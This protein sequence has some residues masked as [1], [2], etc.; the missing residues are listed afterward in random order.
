M[1]TTHTPWP[2]SHSSSLED[3]L[4]EHIGVLRQLR[5]LREGQTETNDRLNVLNNAL[6]RVLDSRSVDSLRVDWLV[7][8]FKLLAERLGTKLPDEKDG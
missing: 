7:R 4:G 1:T 2:S 6:S 8:S 5:D 3:D